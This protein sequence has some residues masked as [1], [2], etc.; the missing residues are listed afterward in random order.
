MF[1]NNKKLYPKGKIMEFIRDDIDG[2]NKVLQNWINEYKSYKV[3]YEDEIK[4]I[5]ETLLPLQ[6]ELL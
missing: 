4:K 3:R 6:N 5:D 1:K 2:I